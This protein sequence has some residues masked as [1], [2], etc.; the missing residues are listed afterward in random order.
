MIFLTTFLTT[1][2]TGLLCY[3]LGRRHGYSHGCRHGYSHG[4][5]HGYKDAHLTIA[6]EIKRL[7][8]FQ[9]ND[10]TYKCTEVVDTIPSPQQ[11]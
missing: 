7:G 9:S 11:E 2:I 4:Y 5:S 6:F 10:K 1:F 8:A 3:L